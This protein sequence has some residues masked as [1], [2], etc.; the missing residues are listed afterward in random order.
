MV[1]LS[2][3]AVAD[4]KKKTDTERLKMPT[5]LLLQTASLLVYRVL[6]QQQIS[7]ISRMAAVDEQNGMSQEKKCNYNCFF[8]QM[9]CQLFGHKSVG[10]C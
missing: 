5:E 2:W 4:P 1:F 7:S 6:Q 3:K 8:S 9:K 10:K